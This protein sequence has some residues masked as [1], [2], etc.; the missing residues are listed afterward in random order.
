LLTIHTR[1]VLLAM[2]MPGLCLVLALFFNTEIYH[3]VLPI[4]AA[5][6][7]LP[8]VLLLA[9]MLLAWS[10]HNGRELHLLLLNG[11]VYWLVK[12]F[13]WEANP[14]V[15]SPS[16]LFALLCV[17]VPIVYVLQALLPEHGVW[18]WQMLRRILL[19]IVPFGLLMLVL[20]LGKAEWV[21]HLRAT[22]W[23]NPW[24]GVITLT[25]PGLI[26]FAVVLLI[27]VVQLCVHASVMRGGG[28]MSL[29]ALALALNSVA[30]P[31]MAMV[32]F[33]IAGA[34]ILI[35][36]MLNSYNLAYLDELT[37][38][39]S[40]RALKQQLMHLRKRYSIVML[41]LDH[42]KQLNDRY[43]HDV[44]DQVLRMVAA[45]L[46]RVGGGGEAFRYGGEE[47]TIVFRNKDAREALIH[48]DALREAIAANPFYVRSRKRPRTK[49]E[50]PVRRGT[51]QKVKV[52]ISAGVAERG[53]KH[54]SIS[55]VFKSADKALYTAK[56]AGRNRVHAI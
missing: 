10:Y 17:L 44:G 5:L 50:K 11:L 38:L 43:G 42:F 31:S 8:L 4:Y 52:T 39:P 46:H 25:Q 51:V 36:V 16:Q 28:I 53:D 6:P 30:Q 19:S 29:L 47:F 21:G 56:R 23:A 40:R 54:H 24:P 49:P 18:R 32:Y 9:G 26:S 14:E 34:A 48:V 33:S 35:S 3:F 55:D 1:R 41:D 7:Y 12:Q 2:L 20:W 13:I 45:Q 15:A 27:L 37:N 22:L